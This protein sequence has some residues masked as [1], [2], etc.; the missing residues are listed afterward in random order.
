M[1]TAFQARQLLR[2]RWNNSS[3][4]RKQNDSSQYGL[5]VVVYNFKITFKQEYSPIISMRYVYMRLPQ[6][7]HCTPCRLF[8]ENIDK[9]SQ[10]IY[11]V[12]TDASEVNI[13]FYR[14]LLNK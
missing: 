8:N 7:I 4:Q 11:L 3:K 9:T 14:T 12:V 5:D 1:L 6:E 10:N 2:V 13:A